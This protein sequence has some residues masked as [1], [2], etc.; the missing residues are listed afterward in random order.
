MKLSARRLLLLAALALAPLGGVRADPHDFEMA[1]HATYLYRLAHFVTWPETVFAGPG[2]PVVIC[3]QGDDPFGPLLDRMVSDR[4]VDGRPIAV[5]RLA[6][7]EPAAG[8]QI[9]YVAGGAAQSQAQA[10]EAVLRAPVVTVTDEARGGPRGMLHVI[11]EGDR[12]RFSIDA[13]QADQSGVAISS[14]LMALAV[15]VKR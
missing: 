2:A 14:K 5:K 4:R 3:V 9:A 7:L 11:H 1:I 8:C 13:A 10:L 15:S 6:R 12:I